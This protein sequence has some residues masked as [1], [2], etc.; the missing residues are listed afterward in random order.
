MNLTALIAF[1]RQKEGLP[2]DTAGRRTRFHVEVCDT[3]L[4]FVLESG[5]RRQESF[6]YVERFIESFL[7]RQSERPADYRETYNASYLIG[8]A[9]E[10]RKAGLC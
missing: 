2:L 6:P 8:L 3:R 9:R 5:A 1:A 7:E 10:Y 4:E